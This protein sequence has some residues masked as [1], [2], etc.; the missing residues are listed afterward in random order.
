MATITKTEVFD[1]SDDAEWDLTTLIIASAVLTISDPTTRI[2]WGLRTWG[3]SPKE[4][5]WDEDY[6][7]ILPADEQHTAMSAD[8]PYTIDD[9]EFYFLVKRTANS[10]SDDD[11]TQRIRWN[12]LDDEKIKTAFENLAAQNSLCGRYYNSD[13]AMMVD[14]R[15]DWNA[16]FAKG[17]WRLVVIRTVGTTIL[18]TVTDEDAALKSS[19]GSGLVDRDAVGTWGLLQTGAS[20]IWTLGGGAPVGEYPNSRECPKIAEHVSGTARLEEASGWTLPADFVSFGHLLMSYCYD[21]D[22]DGD[23]VNDVALVY[24]LYHGGSWS[25]WTSVPSGG[26]MSGIDADAG[27]TLLVGINLSNASKFRTWPGVNR[28]EL[29]YTAFLPDYEAEDEMREVL[30]NL[31]AALEA[32][33]TLQAYNG[34]CGTEVLWPKYSFPNARRACGVFVV[35]RRSP[36]RTV[37]FGKPGGVKTMVKVY[38]HEIDLYAWFRIDKNLEDEVIG[39]TGLLAFAEDVKNALRCSTLGDTIDL[40]KVEDGECDSVPFGL[41]PEDALPAVKIPIIVRS[42]LFEGT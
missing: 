2:E 19:F 31:K 14:D 16:I 41:E 11:F 21:N 39:E 8:D 7:Y 9:A 3:Y 32:D 33:E 22:A 13:G 20:N 42:S 15:G 27:D 10:E 36:E 37:A 17:E 34:W 38:D 24:N 1:F 29:S 40:L 12:T 30:V 26:D 35:P 23:N 4:A 25:G 28:L 5:D 6:N 18:V